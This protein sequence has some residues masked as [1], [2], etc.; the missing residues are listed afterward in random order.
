[1]EETHIHLFAGK[2]ILIV[3]DEYFIADDV[4]H[5]LESAGAVVVGPAPS[6]EAG[7][8]LIDQYTLDGAIL[9]IRLEGETVFPIA[10]RLQQLKIPFVFA[11][12]Y[13]DAD[14]PE[15]YGGYFMSGKPTEMD[16]IAKALFLAASPDH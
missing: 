9:D 16:A 1:M 5:S 3:E 11:T 2:H 6:V 4:R 7:M 12:A 15:Q 13:L 8:S 14:I 10:D